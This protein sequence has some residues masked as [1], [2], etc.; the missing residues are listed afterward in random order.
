MTTKRRLSASV[1]SHL[2]LASEAAIARGRAPSLSAW[3]ND[4]LRL[5]LEHDLRLAALDELISAHEARH[6]VIS[7]EEIAQASRWARAHA[8]VVR[9]APLRPPASRKRPRS[10]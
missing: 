6:G 8:V 10:A 1:D 5:K 7:Q 2:I 9:G 3:V 4:A